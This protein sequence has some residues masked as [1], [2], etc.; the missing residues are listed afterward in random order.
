MI[1]EELASRF[2]TIFTQQTVYATLNKTLKQ[3]HRHKDEL[4][5]VLHRPDVPLGVVTEKVK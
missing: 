5:L 4:L 1:I 2:T 3:L